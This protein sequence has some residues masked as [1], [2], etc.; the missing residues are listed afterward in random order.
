MNYE[1]TATKVR[2]VDGDTID[3]DVDLG[4]QVHLKVRVRLKGVNT[5][6]IYGIDKESEE[7]AEG[8]R[9]KRFVEL[10]FETHAEELILRTEK[11][12]RGKYGRW[13]GTVWPTTDGEWEDEESGRSLNDRLRDEGWGD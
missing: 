12:R 5:P 7:Y 11:D 1:Y 10:W 2:V 4:F 6:E 3:L 9:A 13:I 8:I